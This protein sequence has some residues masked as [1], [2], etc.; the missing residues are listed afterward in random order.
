MGKTL[1]MH[2]L[3]IMFPNT[4]YIIV[5]LTR[6]VFF[7]LNFCVG[8]GGIRR[9]IILELGKIEKFITESATLQDSVEWEK[10]SAQQC[11]FAFYFI[12]IYFFTLSRNLLIYFLTFSKPSN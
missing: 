12:F 2:V 10:A 11:S 9:L 4:L 8:V 6:I 7:F 3:L 1:S 5:R